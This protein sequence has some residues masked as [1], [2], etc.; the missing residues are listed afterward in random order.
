MA[1]FGIKNAFFTGG[2]PLTDPSGLGVSR[3]V[4]ALLLPLLLTALGVWLYQKP[5]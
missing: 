1:V 5:E 3:L 2:V 4:G